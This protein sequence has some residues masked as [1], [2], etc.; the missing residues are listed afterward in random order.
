MAVI[1]VWS[2]FDLILSLIAPIGLAVHKGTA[3][4]VDLDPSGVGYRSSTDLATLVRRGP[5]EDELRPERSGVAVLANGGV[6]IGDA[7]DVVNALAQRWPNVVLRC[8]PHVASASVAIGVVPILPA[9]FAPQVPGDVVYQRTA[10][11]GEVE[12]GSLVL[13]VPRSSTVRALLSGRVPVSRD[14]WI[15]SL[16]EVWS[17]A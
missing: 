12:R 3:L 7:T 1:A 5:T 4:V 6:G 11:G 15:R 10:Y 8:S 13:P 16:G 17:L 9:P 14:R 2:P